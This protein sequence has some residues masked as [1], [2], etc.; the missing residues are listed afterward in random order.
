MNFHKIRLARLKITK[1]WC[2]Y[3]DAPC[4]AKE[5]QK[6]LSK[7]EQI[8]HAKRSTVFSTITK[9]LDDTVL[10]PVLPVVVNTV[11]L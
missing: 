6:L 8:R 2:S 5:K 7:S 10:V 4:K 11:L 3:K 1:G 9:L